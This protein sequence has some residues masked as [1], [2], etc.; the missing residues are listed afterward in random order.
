M[1][2]Q[3]STEW[4]DKIRQIIED[5]HKAR[6]MGEEGRKFIETNFSWDTIAKDFVSISKIYI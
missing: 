4:I 2:K 5:D 1:E 6:R 3:N